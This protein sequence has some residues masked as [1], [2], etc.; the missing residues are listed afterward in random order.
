MTE[1]LV[2]DGE[3][4]GYKWNKRRMIDVVFLD[5]TVCWMD[6]WMVWGGRDD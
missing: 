2:M 4:R 6:D 3:R 5:F 1:E